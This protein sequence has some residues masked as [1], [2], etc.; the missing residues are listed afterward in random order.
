MYA[1]IWSP[2]RSSLGSATPPPL[3]RIA[4]WS[5]A[6]CAAMSSN[7]P[8]PPPPMKGSPPPGTCPF[9]NALPSL[10]PP[11][12]PGKR[13]T[14]RIACSSSCLSSA[15]VSLTAPPPLPNA[16]IVE[17]SSVPYMRAEDAPSHPGGH[18]NSPAGDIMWGMR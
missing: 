6:I 1:A 12:S 7:S 10:P 2:A 16:S 18:G 15:L 4:A 11:S 5:A 14:S 9:M 8:P 17:A 13:P 3:P